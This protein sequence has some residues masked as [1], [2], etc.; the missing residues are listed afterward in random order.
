MMSDLIR[1][2]DQ[3]HQVHIMETEWSALFRQTVL[4]DTRPVDLLR[5][6]V[7]YLTLSKPRTL[8][9]V[10]LNVIIFVQQFLR[11][12]KTRKID[13]VHAHYAGPQWFSLALARKFGGPPFVITLHGSDVRTFSKRDL[14]EQSLTRKA[15]QSASRVVA[16]SRSLAREVVKSIGA[17]KPPEIVY[18]CYPNMKKNNLEFSMPPTITK[19]ILECFVLQVGNLTAV[20]SPDITLKAWK[21]VTEQEPEA[22][23]LFAGEGPELASLKALAAN[24]GVAHRVR[25]LGW[26]PRE[27]V[28]ELMAMA[29]AVVAPSRTEGFGI[30]IVE[31][32][33]KRAPIICSDIGPFS[34]IIADRR[35]G[36]LFPVDNPDAMAEAIL[37]MI[38]NPNSASDMAR[39]LHRKVIE[40]FS[41]QKMARKYEEIYYKYI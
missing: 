18:N 17:I 9:S 35:E 39:R 41:P 40:D 21:K 14:F 13:I 4:T 24:L 8:I 29:R 11:Y 26:L 34:E 10:P 28:L 30:I 23:L 16:V 27:A 3:R 20:K 31:A 5:F 1:E 2:L 38:S 22:W 25:F 6:P 33:L 19:E 36:L 7:P 15:L 37:H 12:C 32:A